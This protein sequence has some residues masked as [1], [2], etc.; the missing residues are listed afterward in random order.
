MSARKIAKRLVANEWLPE[1]LDDDQR[2]LVSTVSQ[3]IEWSGTLAGAFSVALLEDVNMHSEAAR[4]NSA[5]IR[6]RQDPASADGQ[7][8]TLAVA[9]DETLAVIWRSNFPNMP[10]PGDREDAIDRIMKRRLDTGVVARRGRVAGKPVHWV[11]VAARRV[12]AGEDFDLVMQDLA[13]DMG[14]YDATRFKAMEQELRKR[15][16]QERTRPANKAI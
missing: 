2:S 8:A 14:L 1:M 15:I 9:N 13:K 5:L 3:S 11:T 10:Q 4:L 16:E 12:L 6:H 7:R